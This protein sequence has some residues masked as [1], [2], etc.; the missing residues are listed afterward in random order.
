MTAALAALAACGVLSLLAAFV[1]AGTGPFG[2]ALALLLLA[3]WAA[4]AFLCWRELDRL[5]R[6]QGHLSGLNAELIRSND[7]LEQFAAMVS[8]DLKEPLRGVS[9]YVQLLERR[10][11]D[12][13]DD[14]ARSFIGHAVA[15]VRR[16]EA[17]IAELLAFSRIGSGGRGQTEIQAGAAVSTALAHLKG[18]IAEAQAVIDVGSLPVVAADPQQLVSLF[19]NLVGNAVKYRRD[20]VRPEIRVGCVERGDCWEFFV[21]DN[22]IGIAPEHQDQ[23]FGLFRRA[24]KTG[25]AGTGI[26]LAMCRKVVERHGGRIRVDSTPGKGSTFYFTLPKRASA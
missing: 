26:G 20:D 17:L 7:D 11:R 21:K 6:G 13:L 8:H 19:Q 1:L 10:Y 2:L 3:A 18:A 5:K 24:G 22:G 25:R 14:E 16:M 9:S 4:A 15:G 23:V 12:E